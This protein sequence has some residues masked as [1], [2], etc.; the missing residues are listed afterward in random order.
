MQ[1]TGDERLHG[2]DQEGGEEGADVERNQQGGDRGCGQGDQQACQRKSADGTIAPAVV[3]DEMA[4]R[5]MDAAE[6]GD[7]ACQIVT[8][9][10]KIGHGP[11]SPGRAESTRV[12]RIMRRRRGLAQM[13]LPEISSP[14][15][16]SVD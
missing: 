16:R 6:E 5:H 12:R 15:M 7:R 2:H 4:L 10:A 1:A 14:S 11:S 9:V 13:S 8:K 3:I